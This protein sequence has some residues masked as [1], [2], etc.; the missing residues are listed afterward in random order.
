MY[1]L[2]SQTI[3]YPKPFLLGSC[4]S[5][6]SSASFL[7]INLPS[8]SFTLS[9]TSLTLAV[10]ASSLNCISVKL[11]LISAW[12]DLNSAVMKSLDSFTLVSR[13]HNGPYPYVRNVMH[14]WET[15]LSRDRRKRAFGFWLPLQPKRRRGSTAGPVVSLTSSI[16]NFIIVLLNWISDIVLKSKFCNS[17]AESMV[18]SSFI[19]SEFF[20]LV[21]SSSAEWLYEQAESKISSTT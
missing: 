11:F 3:Y 10:R 4:F 13:A 21:I 20:L 15:C 18:S 6:L 5:L 7:S 2:P 1:I 14:Q 19:C 12:L 9:S 8:M 17:V 16:S